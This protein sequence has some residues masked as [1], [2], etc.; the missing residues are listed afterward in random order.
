MHQL[1]FRGLQ[2]QSKSTTE[3]QKG[4]ARRYTDTVHPDRVQPIRLFH[5]VIIFSS[6]YRS[7][8]VVWFT[9][10][11]FSVPCGPLRIAG[12]LPNTGMQ[13]LHRDRP[14]Y[15]EAAHWPQHMLSLFTSSSKKSGASE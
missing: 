2:D 3:V 1:A 10:F 12:G 5:I 8:A 14:A 6:C 7:L 15:G 4:L 13:F 9:Y 11:S